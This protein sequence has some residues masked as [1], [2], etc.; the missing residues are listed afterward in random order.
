ML[1]AKGC[2]QGRRIPANSATWLLPNMPTI[3]QAHSWYPG[4]D[5]VHGFDH[6]LR[7]YHLSE[8]IGAAEGADLRIL[9]AAVL[10]HDAQPGEEE[11]ARWAPPDTHVPGALNNS[12]PHESS[13]QDHHL[14]TAAF[15]AQVLAA[16]NWLLEDVQAVQHCIRAHRFRDDREQPLSL[17]ARVLFDADKLDAIGAIG[18][19]RA[20]AYAACAGQPAFSP[21]SNRFLVSGELEPGEPHSAY[22]EFL[23][24][25]SKI[26]DRLYTPTARVLAEQ[27][28]RVMVDYFTR[29]EMEFHG[30]C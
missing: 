29:L 6:I 4:A 23:F 19:A 25:L 15:A 14:A 20:I 8:Y 1:A 17:E 3:D 28:N 26:K 18:V 16:E 24:K 5:P 30:Q 21:P 9:L 7:V 2:L 27:R 10:L 13:R 22:H 12:P 11:Y